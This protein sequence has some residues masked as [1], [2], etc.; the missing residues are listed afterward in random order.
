M[1]LEKYDTFVS[2]SFFFLLFLFISFFYIIKRIVCLKP[3][4]IYTLIVIA[5]EV[6]C[7]KRNNIF[8]ENFVKN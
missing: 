2:M 6:K 4:L 5:I 3:S 8:V 7:T 1:R